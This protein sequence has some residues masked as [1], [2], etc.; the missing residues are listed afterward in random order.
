MR[1]SWTILLHG[2]SLCIGSCVVSE[3]T[4]ATTSYQNVYDAAKVSSGRS[5]RSAVKDRE[6][7]DAVDEERA[8]DKYPFIEGL[9]ELKIPL[10]SNRELLAFLRGVDERNKLTKFIGL[11]NDRLITPEEFADGLVKGGIT[12]TCICT[13]DQKKKKEA[14]S[15][16]SSL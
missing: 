9:N 8:G 12:P 6:A 13:R 4:V 10:L 11:R 3:S 7:T 1:T 5:L 14:T 15:S 2:V 16:T